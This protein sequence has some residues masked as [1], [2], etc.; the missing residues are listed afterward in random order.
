MKDSN[1]SK[2]TF[3]WNFMVFLDFWNF[4]IFWNFWNFLKFFWDYL[5]IFRILLSIQSFWHPVN[6]VNV[7]NTLCKSVC[8]SSLILHLYGS[9]C[10]ALTIT[11]LMAP[12]FFRYLYNETVNLQSVMTALTTLYA[13]HKY[14]CPGLAKQVSHTF[15]RIAKNFL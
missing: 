5:E 3:S 12:L 11:F 6:K 9:S 1:L 2:S 7:Q 8:T 4:G 10:S 14:M 15:W 13:A